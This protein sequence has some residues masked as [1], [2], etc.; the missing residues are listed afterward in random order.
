M[1]GYNKYDFF[2]M[3]M[4]S[5]LVFGEYG[6]GL[7]AVRA[8]VLLL[9]PFT[10]F[11][12]FNKSHKGL[13][14]YRY[15]CVFLYFWWMY[16]VGTLYKSVDFTASIKHVGFL[17]IHI[18]GFLEVLWAAL[19]ANRPKRSILNGW[20][21]LLVLTIPYAFYEYFT[22]LHLNVSIQDTGE[23]LKIGNVY[24]E[25]PF[26]S[27]TYGNLNSYNTVL[28]WAL[29]FVFIRNL[30]PEKKYDSTLGMV[31]LLLT[32]FIIVFNSS[33]G[34]LLCLF[35][36]LT[37]YSYCYLHIGKHKILFAIFVS[38]IVC[39]A[40]YFLID[41]FALIFDRFDTQG[42]EDDGR[43]ENIYK[44]I[45]AFMDSY[46][47]GIGIGNY[48]P[49][50]SNIYRVRIPAPHNLYLEILTIYGGL[51]FCGFIGMVL[52]I[53]KTAFRC[54]SYGHYAFYLCVTSL[55]FA[56]IIDSSYI[57]KAQTWLYLASLYVILDNKYNP[58]E[59]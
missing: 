5:L 11:D 54:G 55:F 1:K 15:E 18:L 9:F 33:R 20:L 28:C 46:G 42:L 43:S 40:A 16:S 13:Y 52:R 10:I 12:L 39:I 37:V 27:V 17:L 50:M 14:Y 45:D 48:D 44:G 25:R 51:V 26:A 3:F 49:I 38:I 2:L 4:L 6:G 30:F 22:D 47:L 23:H 7:Q 31:V 8:F 29:P 19:K 57:M 59:K 53:I 32:M 56:G 41:M 34:A 21:L 58:Q 24:I 36:L 35:V